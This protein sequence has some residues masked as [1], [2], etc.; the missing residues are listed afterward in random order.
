MFDLSIELYFL[1]VCLSVSLPLTH[2]LTTQGQNRKSKIEKRKDVHRRTVVKFHSA[3]CKPLGNEIGCT[4]RIM[5]FWE[6]GH[7][8]GVEKE[9]IYQRQSRKFHVTTTYTD[10]HGGIIFK[11]FRNVAGSAFC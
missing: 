8:L 4:R 6:R 2:S 11:T 1:S 7:E 5:C 9:S 10:G 3:D